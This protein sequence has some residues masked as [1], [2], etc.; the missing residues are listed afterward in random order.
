LISGPQGRSSHCRQAPVTE[1]PTIN[2]KSPARGDIFR[3]IDMSSTHQQLLY[4][5]VFSTKKRKPYLSNPEF[6]RSVF[7]Y[8]AGVAKNLDGF[9]LEIDGWIDH[10][11]L[12][13]RIPARIAVADFVGKLKANTSKHVN[14][15][16]GK[17]QK[18]GWQDGY[19]AFSVSVSQKHKVAEYIQNQS[20]HHAIEPFESEYIQLLDKHEVEYDPRFV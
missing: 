6:R 15:T 7:G 3:E 17:I 11:H 20:I 19:G 14:E 10:T 5:I 16:S 8:L 1:S 2:K 13:V 12:L 18:F 9:A 4:H